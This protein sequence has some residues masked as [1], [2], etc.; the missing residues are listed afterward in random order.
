MARAESAS[1]YYEQGYYGRN[2][3]DGSAVRKTE[4]PSYAPNVRIKAAPAP[5]KKVSRQTAAQ[6]RANVRAKLSVLGAILLVAMAAFFV[7]CRGVM[8]T[9]TTNRI[10]KSQKELSNLVATNKRMEMEIEEAL[11]LKNV[12]SVATEKLGMRRPE[13]YQTVYV[14][15]PQVDHVEKTVHGEVE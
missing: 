13:K 12:E 1:F 15:L 14:T 2:Y 9:E 10:E 8:I 5:K 4:L 7:L 6:R 3:Y 11:D